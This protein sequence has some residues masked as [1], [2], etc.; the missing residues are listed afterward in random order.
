[1]RVCVTW[2][3]QDPAYHDGVVCPSHAHKLGHCYAA[4]VVSIGFPQLRGSHSQRAYGGDA[5]TE[6]DAAPVLD[7]PQRQHQVPEGLTDNGLCAATTDGVQVRHGGG[8]I[9]Y[10]EMYVH[11]TGAVS[12]IDCGTAGGRARVIPCRLGYWRALVELTMAEY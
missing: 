1:M 4:I 5:A 3:L 10:H 9:E 7:R 11:Y 2:W 8:T 12:A 6:G